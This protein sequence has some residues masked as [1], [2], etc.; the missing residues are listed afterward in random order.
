MATG[1]EWTSA[2]ELAQLIRRVKLSPVELVEHLLARIEQVNPTIKEELAAYVRSPEG[3]TPKGKWADKK[4]VE[5]MGSAEFNAKLEKMQLADFHGHGF[6][7]RAVWKK[8]AKGNLLDEA[9]QQVKDDDPDRWKKAV[10]L[11]DIHLEKGMHCADCHFTIDSHGDGKL[12]G[13]LRAATAIKC[14]D[15]HGTI[16]KISDLKTTGNAGGQDLAK[17]RTPSAKARSSRKSPAVSL[18]SRM[19]KRRCINS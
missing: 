16:Q 6:V 17:T 4:F 8:D 2:T 11:K 14:Q 1:L 3:S 5:E 10:H 12:Y 19:P 13:E 18:R 7:F 9:G 15:C